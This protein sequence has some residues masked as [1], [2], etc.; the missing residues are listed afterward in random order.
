MF[1]KN[2]KCKINYAEFNCNYF[3]IKLVSIN[4]ITYYLQITSWNKWNVAINLYLIEL[5]YSF[6]GNVHT[7]QMTLLVICS[8]LRRIFL[9]L[10]EMFIIKFIVFSISE[11]PKFY[12][13]VCIKIHK[14][15]TLSLILFCF[16]R[17]PYPSVMQL[18]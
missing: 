10:I 12:L 9:F 13:S 15:F 3:K 17:S 4:H 6:Q 16:P 5:F 7:F 1:N 2:A 14:T 8:L 11:Y 18:L